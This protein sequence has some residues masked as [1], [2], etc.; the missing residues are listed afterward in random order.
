MTGSFRTHD[1]VRID[2]IGRPR[3]RQQTT[4]R[5]CVRPIKRDEIGINVMNEPRQVRLSR[6]IAHHLRQRSGRDR[7]SQSKL[8]RLGE[9]RNDAAVVSVNS[10]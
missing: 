7:N 3:T 8:S 10:D 5:S 2:N 9:K 4:D 1:D 6:G